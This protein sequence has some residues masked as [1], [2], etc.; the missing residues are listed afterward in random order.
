MS[1]WDDFGMVAYRESRVGIP[2]S[3]ALKES[4]TESF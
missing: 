1:R 4:L 3:D 2:H